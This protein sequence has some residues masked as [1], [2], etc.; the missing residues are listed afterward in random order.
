MGEALGPNYESD[1]GADTNVAFFDQ[2]LQSQE[3][4]FEFMLLSRPGS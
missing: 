2:R 1:L 4:G 3:T